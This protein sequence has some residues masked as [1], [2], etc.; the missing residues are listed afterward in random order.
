MADKKAK[1]WKKVFHPLCLFGENFEDLR[2]ADCME[3]QRKSGFCYLQTAHWH[4]YR[5]VRICDLKNFSEFAIC[6]LYRKF[7]CPALC[8]HDVKPSDTAPLWVQLRPK[9]WNR[10]KGSHST[11]Y[12]WEVIK[13]FLFY[14][15]RIILSPYITLLVDALF[16][17][18]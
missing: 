4:A 17:Q 6:D 15:L 14:Y 9:L 10:G 5:N 2:L 8:K 12:S 13:P 18:T 16:I 1:L 7:A 11:K 3:H